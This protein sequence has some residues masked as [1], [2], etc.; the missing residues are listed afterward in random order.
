MSEGEEEKRRREG[1]R[2]EGRKGGGEGGGEGGR[3]EGREEGREGSETMDMARSNT[4]NTAN[5]PSCT[6]IQ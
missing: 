5:P 3:E 6:T 2:E 1:G 4:L